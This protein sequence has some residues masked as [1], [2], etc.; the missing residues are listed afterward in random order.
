MV[1]IKKYGKKYEEI[2]NKLITPSTQTTWQNFENDKSGKFKTGKEAKKG[3][4]V[5]WQRYKNGVP[6]WKG[7][8]G[9]VQR[10]NKDNFETIEGNTNDAGGR[11][12]YIVAE[13]TR[14]YDWDT[15]NGLRL[16]GFI[17]KK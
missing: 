8:A 11:E 14:T 15:I 1:W 4:I 5:I 7:H 10:V 2:L 16:K 6:E 3:A 17:Y 13:K 9:I 12:G